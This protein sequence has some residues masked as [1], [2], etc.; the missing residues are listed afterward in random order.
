MLAIHAGKIIS[1]IM[2][3]VYDMLCIC[4]MFRHNCKYNTC[5]YK[6]HPYFRDGVKAHTEKV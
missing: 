6:I 1:G 5:I 4:Y 3:Y 2:L